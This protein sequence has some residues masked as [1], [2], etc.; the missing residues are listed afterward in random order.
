MNPVSK[1]IPLMR[2]AFSSLICRFSL[3]SPGNR[4]PPVR[5]PYSTPCLRAMELITILN[6]CYRFKR[7]G[8]HHARFSPDRNS[9]EVSVRPRKARPRSV[10]AV[11]KRRPATIDS[12]NGASSSFHCGDFSF[13]CTRC[14]VSIAAA[15]MRSSLRRCRGFGLLGGVA[16]A[17]RAL[18]SCGQEK[19]G[20]NRLRLGERERRFC[21]SSAITETQAHPAQS[22]HCFPQSPTSVPCHSRFLPS[23]PCS[24]APGWL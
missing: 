24:S 19:T 13:C 23:E 6:R 16:I 3:C 9:M 21:P 20:G 14:D 5:M 18:S 22:L 17:G 11:A 8:Y 7:F 10:C 12:T 1:L 15:A 2:I 4:M